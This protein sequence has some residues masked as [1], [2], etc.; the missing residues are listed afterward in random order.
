MAT[1][2]NPLINARK[3][4]RNFVIVWIFITFVLGVATFLA[5]YFAYSPQES[6]ES[7]LNVAVDLNNG[8]DVVVVLPSITAKPT[9]PVTPTQTAS[10]EPTTDT[11]VEAV[12]EATTSE[13]ADGLAVAQAAT[14]AIVLPS[15]TPL[16]VED[17]RF[18]LGIQVQESPDYNPDNQDNWY[19]SVTNDL[20]LRWI[21]Q[22]VR[23]ET[24][25][26]EKGNINWDMLDLVMGSA[27]RFNVHMM[28]SIVTAPEWAREAGVDTSQVGPP[29]DPQDYVDFVQAII[30]RYPNQ[31]HA[32]EVWN[33]QNIDREWT[34]AK[35]LDASQYVELLRAAYQGIKEVDP[36][37]IVISGALSPT[38]FND[39]IGAWDDFTYMEQLIDAGMLNYLDCVGAHHNGYN[40]G[41]SI[42]YDAVPDDPTAQFRG[43]FD[44]EH[45]SW[46][47][48]STLEGYTTR[49]RNAGSDAK[50]CVTEFGWASAEDLESVRTGFEFAYDNTL[51]EQAEWIPEAA[52]LMEDWGT[53]WLA[54]VWNF[55]YGPQAGWAVDNDNVPYSLIGP[56]FVFRPAYDAIR[57]WQTE[58]LANQ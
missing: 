33:E 57:N 37:I 1:M 30:K 20:G 39:G 11:A 36:G 51:E 41:P 35:G 50:L 15:P 28:L 7:A 3:Q 31:V 47:L 14:E 8:A 25:E 44:N 18:Q 24:L 6:N 5:I 42:T 21:K 34:S 49:I 29:A 43:P 10:P 27:E 2:S 12:A 54:F 55:N 26:P 19:R 40:I 48:R 22:Q 9:D 53:V 32:I 38:G 17:E 23:W 16:P 46:S 58:H 52:T 13:S 45:H 56:D 4:M